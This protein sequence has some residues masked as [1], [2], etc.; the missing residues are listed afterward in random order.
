MIEPVPMDQR[1]NIIP[2]PLPP[3]VISRRQIADTLARTGHR[4][5]PYCGTP[6]RKGERG[7]IPCRG[8]GYSYVAR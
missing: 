1:G 7:A 4:K 5:C 6:A 8:C 2:L 3:R